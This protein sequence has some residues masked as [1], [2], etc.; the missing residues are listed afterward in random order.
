MIALT[1]IKT[2]T[3]W[4]VGFPYKREGKSYELPTGDHERLATW[5][6]DQQFTPGGW[7][8]RARLLETLD[9]GVRRK[10]PP[11]P[12]ALHRL[13]REVRAYNVQVLTGGSE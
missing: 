13:G 1:I 8:T 4:Y 12:F 3:K 5:F 6:R 11:V 9:R 7:P 2:P 10:A